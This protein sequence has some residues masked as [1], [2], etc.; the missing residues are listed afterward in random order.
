VVNRVLNKE[1]M[2][3]L[4]FKFFPTNIKSYLIWFND[5]DRTYYL[6]SSTN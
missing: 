4:T 2:A 5:I 3:N 1:L 6:K